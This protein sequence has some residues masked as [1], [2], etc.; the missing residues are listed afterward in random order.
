MKTKTIPLYAVGNRLKSS[1]V[2][3]DLILAGIDKFSNRELFI[4]YN[5]IRVLENQ[6]E[7]MNADDEPGLLQGMKLLGCED[8]NLFIESFRS[9][10][11]HEML[12]PIVGEREW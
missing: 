1:W 2:L 11:E 7:G 5:A 12:A 9:E 4:R 10:F 8:P 3:N 6:L